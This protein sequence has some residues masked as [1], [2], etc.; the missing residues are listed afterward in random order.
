MNMHTEHNQLIQPL[1][2][3]NPIASDVI[4]TT[5][6]KQLSQNQ[7]YDYTDAADKVLF[8]KQRYVKKD[9][10]KSYAYSHVN[11]E[12]V[13]V[14]TM[15]PFA[16][17]TPL[18][19]LHRFSKY[20]TSTLYFVEGEKCVEA[21]TKLKLLAT[22]SGGAT[23]DDKADFSPLAGRNVIMWPD[24]DD[25]GIGYMQRVQQ[26]LL[27]L[28]VSVSLIDID[29]LDLP[30]K[31][32][33]CDWLK[34]FALNN[35]QSATAADIEG[36]SL[37]RKVMLSPASDLKQTVDSNTLAF[38]DEAVVKRLA[39]LKTIEY[40]RVREAEAKSLGVRAVTLDKLVK[41]AKG[42][43]ETKADSTVLFDD[44]EP[45]HEP[46]NPSQLLID[47]TDTIKS[48]IAIDNHQAQIAA[49]WITSSWF[50]DVVHTAPFALI[51][52]PEKAC[53]KTQL[54]TVLSKLAD[55]PLQSANMSAST[56]Y[57][58][59][60]AHQPTLFIDEVETFLR[61]NE[62]LR[63]ILNAG[64][65]RDS[66]YVMR[67]V[68]DDHEVHKFSVWAF[69]AIAGI[70]AVKLAETITSRSIVFEL[71]KKLATE[72]V[73]RLRYAQS[74]LFADLQS[75]LARFRDD[76]S[77]R[78]K[79]ARPHL[80]DWLGDR[81]QDNFEPLLQVATVAGDQWLACAIQAIQLMVAQTQTPNNANEL[82]ADIQEVFEAKSVNKIT[83]S[84]L[85]TALCDDA[86]KSWL[87]YNRGRQLT[88]RQL[89]SKLKNYSITSKQMRFNTYENASRG[90]ELTQ[91]TDVFERY[92]TDPQN[93]PLHVTKSLE[94]N[95]G[96][97][98]AVTDS[99]TVTLHDN[100]PL[101]GEQ[102]LAR[103]SVNVTD[104]TGKTQGYD[105]NA[106][107]F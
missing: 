63:G 8:T 37:E 81:E 80:P 17:G 85:I 70:N 104:V 7:R 1:A 99:E 67:C 54:L 38:N 92:L 22:T 42:E 60:E 39:S 27:T 28:N 74:D 18:Y 86:E 6:A 19:N 75:K 55:K 56:L 98:L 59:I 15:P 46:I 34:A 107:A 65:T 10:S 49:L 26:K 77:D 23:S 47:I 41:E 35:E 66:A 95:T 103:V 21:L 40:E 91:F 43:R 72:K 89:S 90:Y 71:R 69:K 3:A 97:G 78:V 57:R 87:T 83:T 29:A 58:V 33:I 82:L 4:D 51:N 96:G 79:H 32:D 30:A 50:I 31:G 36:L 2:L 94:A 14:K 24:N 76:Y 53:G 84:E 100:N 20:P 105:S 62:E 61:D 102:A 5:T 64:H 9:N 16:N 93:L 48:F 11:S 101:H 25:A 73:T 106:E 44:I 12:G 13:T 45:W 52:A 88:P 68:G